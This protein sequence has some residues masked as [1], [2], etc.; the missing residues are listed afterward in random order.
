MGLAERR[1]RPRRAGGASRW[2][3]RGATG[4]REAA[5]WERDGTTEVTRSGPRRGNSTAENR[6]AAV[7]HSA[8]A[9]GADDD[10]GRNSPG[11]S[12]GVAVGGRRAGGVGV[13]ARG[14]TMTRDATSTG[15]GR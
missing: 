2:E 11:W 9:A 15:S 13:T 7:V 8:G 12:G 10:N 3:R 5:R 4:R 14:A 1:W 6:G